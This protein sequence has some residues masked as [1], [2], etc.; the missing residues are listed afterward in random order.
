[1]ILKVS[2]TLF[3]FISYHAQNK[4]S[5]NISNNFYSNL[6][7]LSVWYIIL[8]Q[9]IFK[10][11]VL[12]FIVDQSIY[13]YR[14][15]YGNIQ[16]RRGTFIDKGVIYSHISHHC[17]GVHQ[18]QYR[19]WQKEPIGLRNCTKKHKFAGSNPTGHLARLIVSIGSM[20]IPNTVI[21]IGSVRL[22]PER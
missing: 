15:S 4:V 8:I 21:N 16:F 2:L 18:Y 20:V 1:M 9:T 6:L 11:R 10:L 12:V 17:S 7:L 22:F 14:F 19:M 13:N 3:L 5:S